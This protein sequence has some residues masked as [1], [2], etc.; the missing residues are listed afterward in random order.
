MSSAHTPPNHKYYT[1]ARLPDAQTT[2]VC[3]GYVHMPARAYSAT[4]AVA[5]ATRARRSV[6]EHTHSTGARTNARLHARTHART[7]R[8]DAQCD[9]ARIP[10]GGRARRILS[11]RAECLHEQQ[12]KAFA[13]RRQAH[14]HTQFTATHV[15]I[16]ARA[17]IAGIASDTRG[18]RARACA[19]A[20]LPSPAPADREKCA[21]LDVTSSI[22]GRAL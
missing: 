4:R 14:R 19:T 21:Q 5:H 12:A 1:R 7:R 15:Q 9:A 2:F 11:Q 6:P 10:Y 18:T 20:A 8:R 22:T 16:L 17:W 13:R 3:H